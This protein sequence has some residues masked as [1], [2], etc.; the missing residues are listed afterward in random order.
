MYKVWGV[1]QHTL[2]TIESIEKKKREM[3]MFLKQM[4]IETKTT[5]IQ[6]KYY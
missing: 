5:K 3:K 4:K 2:L 1:K 6:Q